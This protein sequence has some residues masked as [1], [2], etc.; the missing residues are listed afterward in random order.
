MDSDGGTVSSNQ[1]LVYVMLK[2]NNITGT[3]STGVGSPVSGI[4]QQ[5]PPITSK[6]GNTI[7]VP[8][9]H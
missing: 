8:R 4:N 2:H 6:A 9:F 7:F 3:L 5:A 1:A